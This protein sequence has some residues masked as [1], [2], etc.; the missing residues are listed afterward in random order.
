MSLETATF[1][2]D[3]ID[4]NPASGDAKSQGDDHIRMIKATL[5]NTFT[6]LNGAV[7]ATV[8]EMNYLVGVNSL[9]QTQLDAK[10]DDTEVGNADGDI[11]LSNG[12]LNVNL[13]ADKWDGSNLI[14]RTTDPDGT[15]GVDGDVCLVREV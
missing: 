3:L 1:I 7:N 8:E 10:V 5:K 15:V 4:T 13:N 6:A 11:P 12:S 14:V 9:I 2:S